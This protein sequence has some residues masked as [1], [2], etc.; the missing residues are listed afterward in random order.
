MAEPMSLE[1]HAKVSG[2]IGRH[3][4]LADATLTQRKKR[5]IF[6]WK[7]VL[8]LFSLSPVMKWFTG[9]LNDKL[10]VEPVTASFS[11][12]WQSQDFSWWKGLE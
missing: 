4:R 12:C 8:A 10:P 2:S 6:S 9:S 11:Y 5:R 3:V 1:L 7:L